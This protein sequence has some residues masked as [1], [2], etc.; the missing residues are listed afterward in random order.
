[1][2]H[3]FDPFSMLNFNAT[4]FCCVPEHSIIPVSSECQ[5]LFPAKVISGLT[6]WTMM[7][8]QEFTVCFSQTGNTSGCLASHIDS[9]SELSA[10]SVIFSV[11]MRFCSCSTGA[12]LRTARVEGRSGAWDGSVL[13]GSCGERNRW[14][15]LLSTCPVCIAA[16]SVQK[17][18]T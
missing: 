14:D 2:N 1:M 16:N 7:S 9:M 3:A 6:R 5:H 8:H 4:C 13:H 18:P 11:L 10:I 15:F 17:S 12:G